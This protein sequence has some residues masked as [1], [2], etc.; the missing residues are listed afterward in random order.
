MKD[1]LLDYGVLVGEE[2][3][4]GRGLLDYGVLVGEEHQQGRGGISYWIMVFLLVKNTNKGGV[5]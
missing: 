5:W 4:Q 2:H 3:Q 1:K